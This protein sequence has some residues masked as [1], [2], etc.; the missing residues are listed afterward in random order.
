[1][2]SVDVAS[3]IKAFAKE[4]GKQPLSEHQQKRLSHDFAN[5]L[6]QVNQSYA[7]EHHAIVFVSGAVVTG[8]K[9]VTA[10]IQSEIFSQIN[11]KSE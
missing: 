1:M 10:E 5:A 2:V 6:T 4:S 3:I 7:K 11:L 9:D 8:V